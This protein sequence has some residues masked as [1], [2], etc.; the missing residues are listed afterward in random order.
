M[1]GQQTYFSLHQTAFIYLITCI[2]L[3][4]ST[5]ESYTSNRFKHLHK[6]INLK[7]STFYDISF[8]KVNELVIWITLAETP[9]ETEIE[10]DFEKLIEINYSLSKRMKWQIILTPIMR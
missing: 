2:I 7:V 10:T 3:C 5:T 9:S 8:L 4:S 6:Q 1:R